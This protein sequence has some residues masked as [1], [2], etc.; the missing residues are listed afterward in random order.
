M[1]DD[2]KA[3]AGPGEPRPERRPPRPKRAAE[4]AHRFYD[5]LF[6][7][8]E[9]DS[10]DGALL[11]GDLTREIAL[12]R[13]VVRRAVAVGEPTETI[14]RAIARLGQILRVQHVLSGD[15]AHGLDEALA[16]VLEEIC[17]KQQKLHLAQKLTV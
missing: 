3:P 12:L 15:A 16:K 5:D 13:I 14:P 9:R 1:V 11:A 4:T 7:D 2:D 6:T 8:E 10:L 17:R